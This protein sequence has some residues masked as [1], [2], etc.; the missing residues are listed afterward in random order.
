LFCPV[1][2]EKRVIFVEY[3]FNFWVKFVSVF[4]VIFND[5][6][7]KINLLERSSKLG[8]FDFCFGGVGLG[9]PCGE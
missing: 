6:T 1:F 7:P 4:G 5:F 8:V 2:D 9:K 3:F